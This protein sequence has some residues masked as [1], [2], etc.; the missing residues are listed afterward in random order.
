MLT[1]L[2]T[3]QGALLSGSMLLCFTDLV[4]MLSNFLFVVTDAAA[5]FAFVPDRAVKPF[6]PSLTFTSKAG[7]AFPRGI[8]FRCSPQS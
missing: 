1:F 8:L 3:L 2:L 5:K 6:Q 4:A 7:G